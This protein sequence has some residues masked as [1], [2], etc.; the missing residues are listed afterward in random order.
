MEGYGI[1]ADDIFTR[2]GLLR[3]RSIDRSRGRVGL[4]GKKLRGI[5]ERVQVSA[6]FGS[7]YADLGS[8][9]L[10]YGAEGD[11]WW[12]GDGEVVHLGGEGVEILPWW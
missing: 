8:S 11:G 7:R 1:V 3:A 9:V 4:G 5:W 6:C 2:M 12:M 10:G